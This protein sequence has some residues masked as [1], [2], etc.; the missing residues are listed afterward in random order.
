MM[1][2]LLKERGSQA[3]GNIGTPLA[4]LDKDAN[5][6]IL[7]TSSFTLHYTQEAKPNIYVILPITPDHLD[8]HGGF[9][10]YEADKLKP[11]SQ[12]QEGEAVILP[13]KYADIPTAGFKIVYDDADDLAKYFGFDTE[14]INFKGAFLLDA[15]IALGVDKILFDNTDY[16][17]INTFTMDPHRQEE[18]YDH[19]DRLWV[20]DTKATNIDAT[21]EA[22]KVYKDKKIHLILGGDDKGVDL[23]TLFEHLNTLHVSLYLIGTNQERTSALASE[24]NITYLTCKSIKDAVRAIDKIHTQTDIALLSPAASSLDQFSSYAQRGNI[25]KDTVKQLS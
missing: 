8:W 6:W 7:E 11:L 19:R 15:V 24:F 2:H 16:K 22:L 1:Q 9:E 4:K 14:K 25:F 5:I 20:N 10:A 18:F 13:R 23:R 21:L 12:M 3:G 17:K